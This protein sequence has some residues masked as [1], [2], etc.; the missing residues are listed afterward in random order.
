[1]AR[2]QRM[3][4]NRRQLRALR[5]PL[6]A[7]NI[8]VAQVTQDQ[9]DEA[10]GILRNLV[11]KKKGMPQSVRMAFNQ[12]LRKDGKKAPFFLAIQ[13]NPM[14]VLTHPAFQIGEDKLAVKLLGLEPGDP[15]LEAYPPRS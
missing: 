1:M 6:P 7:D 8:R 13:G 5:N 12:W 2:T 14:A 4:L 10:E 9:I 15:V 3:R 11:M